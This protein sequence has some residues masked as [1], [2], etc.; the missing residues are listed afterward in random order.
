M[1][2]AALLRRWSQS[3]AATATVISAV[4]V[5]LVAAVVGLGVAAVLNFG[6]VPGIG[7]TLILAAAAIG[8]GVMYVD[9][10][11]TP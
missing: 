1:N 10:K 9:K 2:L 8:P 5:T 7:V 3:R 11:L 6:T 4:L